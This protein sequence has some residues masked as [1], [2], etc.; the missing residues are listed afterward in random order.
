MTVIDCPVAPA[1][2]DD[3]VEAAL[4]ALLRDRDVSEVH[5]LEGGF[6]QVLRRGRR[7]RL[8]AVLEGPLFDLVRDLVRERVRE[9]T[10]EHRTITLRLRGGHRLSAAPCLDGRHAL[11]VVKAPTLDVDLTALADEGL[12]PPGMPAELAAAAA[13]GGVLVLGASRAGRQ[14]LACAVARAAQRSLAFAAVGERTAQLFPSPAGVDVAAQARAADALGFDALFA[15][16]LEP[17]DCLQL[18]HTGPALPL[19]AS[20]RAPT[21]DALGHA[22]GDASAGA[23]ATL[24]CVVGVGPDGRPQLVEVHGAV[25]ASGHADAAS[26]PP[27]PAAATSRLGPLATPA[28]SS[29]ARDEL[30]ALGALPSAWASDAPDDD[31]G[32]ELAGLAGDAPA[33]T[34][35]SFDAAL[36]RQAARPPFS[37][38]APRPHP[39]AAALA[40]NP[41]GGLTFEP[42]AAPPGS[43]PG[44][45]GAGQGDPDE[46]PR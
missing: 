21:P 11:R 7:E 42:P 36:A 10:E 26:A 35:G 13:Q 32:W 12:V 2:V 17:Q 45:V 27:T 24:V 15:L 31:P 20:V 28:T 16:E 38:R 39:Q 8:D 30:P 29:D 19:V 44:D 25:D 40:G 22:L 5:C 34:P 46:E 3:A 4:G 6:L 33:P 14:R 23:L 41:F 18:L 37:P 9:P 1:A 43:E